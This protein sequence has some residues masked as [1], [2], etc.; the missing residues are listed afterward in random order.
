MNCVTLWTWGLLEKF[1]VAPL[2]RRSTFFF[3]T[4]SYSFLHRTLSWAVWILSISAHL[5]PCR[6][7]ST[8]R[9]PDFACIF[10]VIFPASLILDISHFKN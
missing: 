7:P 6:S 4:K 2:V 8:C 9:G 3:I 1:M 5:I 10:Y